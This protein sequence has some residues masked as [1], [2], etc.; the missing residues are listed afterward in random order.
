MLALTNYTT[1]LA[2]VS[3]CLSEEQKN[4]K[5]RQEGEHD[6]VVEQTNE[7]L[8]VDSTAELP[9]EKYDAAGKQRM[10]VVSVDW[11]RHSVHRK[12]VLIVCYFIL[13]TRTIFLYFHVTANHR[14]R[15]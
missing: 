12:T 4:V 2:F 11:R 5:G 1:L 13:Y 15:W 14:G 9:Q 3:I 7:H 6:M 10:L 8:P